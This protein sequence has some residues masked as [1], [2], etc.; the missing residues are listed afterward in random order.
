MWN[1]KQFYY[2]VIVNYS[3][4]LELMKPDHRMSI[5]TFQFRN[6][7]LP[8]PISFMDPLQQAAEAGSM[9]FPVLRCNLV[10]SCF[11][12]VEFSSACV[13]VGGW[14][15]SCVFEKLDRLP[16]LCVCVQGGDVVR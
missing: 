16:A 5:C 3:L 2:Q 14:Q 12:G 15:L 4:D 10:P 8:H 7:L 1:L 9:A 13:I 11:E 6:L